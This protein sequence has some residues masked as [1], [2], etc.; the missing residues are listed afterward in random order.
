VNAVSKDQVAALEE[1][2][3][4]DQLI[5]ASLKN[6]LDAMRKRHKNLEL[7]LDQHKTQLIEA[8]VSKDKMRK[9]LDD[10]VKEPPITSPTVDTSGQSGV[11]QAT[12]DELVR[13]SNDKI[14]KLRTRVKQQ[15]EVST[16]LS[17]AIDRLAL[18]GAFVCC[19][20]C[21]AIS[22]RALLC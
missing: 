22:A 15:K 12:M 8:L 4:T 3:A 16:V 6:E 11:D 18:R 13:K 2:K 21:G 9:E 7:E 19:L 1:L 14:E 5:S 20:S 10:A 17:V